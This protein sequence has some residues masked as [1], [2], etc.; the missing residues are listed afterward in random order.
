METFCVNIY[1]LH[2]W[3]EFM[4]N[5][6]YRLILNIFVIILLKQPFSLPGLLYDHTIDNEYYT[7]YNAGIK[8]IPWQSCISI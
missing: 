3:I 6:I 2:F 8:K 1:S 5:R 4:N 7:R